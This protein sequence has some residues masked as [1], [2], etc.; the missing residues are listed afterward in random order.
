M[1]RNEFA[2]ALKQVCAERGLEQEIVLDALRSALIAA[3]RKDHEE[4]DA[5][6][7]SV[8]VDP[9]SGEANIYDENKDVTPPGFGRIAAQT[10]KQVILQ[11]I[12]EAEKNAIIE[13]FEGKVDLIVSA[14]VQRFEGQ[15]VIMDLGKTSGILPPQERVKT[16]QYRLNQRLKVVI[17]KIKKDKRGPEIVVSR[18]DKKLVEGLFDT[19]VPEIRSGAVE[20]MGVAREP[21]SRSKVSVKSNQDG[22]DPIGSCVGQKGVRVQAVTRE[23]F[24]EK[25]DLVN[26][27]D[28]PEKYIVAALSPAKV[29]DIKTNN[30][31]RKA[32]VYVE[33]EQLSLAI[34]K[35]GQN[36]RLAAKLTGWKIDIKKMGETKVEMEVDNGGEKEEAK[37]ESELTKAGLNKRIV[38]ALEN[39]GVKSLAKL[40][41]KSEKELKEIKGLGPKAI[42]EIKKIL[43]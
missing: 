19:E 39:A 33:E 27:S 21:G 4:I 38:K 30:T 31:Q 3:Y 9:D 41:E 37:T 16:E 24:D 35:E 7:L 29:S 14:M 6:K 40:K 8:V 43:R 34:G 11:K 12:R 5:S 17:K 32:T 23:L 18:S 13:T 28:N 42:L 20:I 1:P 26:Y 22:V 36:A 25:I 2:S 15:N 10:A